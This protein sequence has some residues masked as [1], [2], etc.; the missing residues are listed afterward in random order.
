MSANPVDVMIE[1]LPTMLDEFNESEIE[2]WR[3]LCEE[4][5]LEP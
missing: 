2:K 5:V 1:L 4:P 3:A